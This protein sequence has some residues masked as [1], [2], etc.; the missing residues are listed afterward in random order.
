MFAW[1]QVYQVFRT[2]AVKTLLKSIVQ[3]P[4]PFSSCKLKPFHSFRWSF[5]SHFLFVSCTQSHREA[6]RTPVWQLLL[7]GVVHYGHGCCSTRP[8]APRPAWG[9]I[10]PGLRCPSTRAVRG[11]QFASP[12]TTGLSPAHA[13]AYSVCGS[14]YWEGRPYH[15]ERHQADT[16]Q[17]RPFVTV[18]HLNF[19]LKT[20]FIRL[21]ISKSVPQSGYSSE[22]KCRCSRKTHHN[23]LDTRGLLL[24]LSHDPGH[25]AEGSQ[26][27]QDVSLC[28]ALPR[29]R[30]WRHTIRRKGLAI[31]SAGL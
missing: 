13:R 10:F 8:S 5:L 23:P 28:A 25:H 18:G 22:G 27:D 12:Q 21:T 29:R 20:R 4:S 24:R 31:T 15:Q 2:V 17:V 7:E 16:I 19:M 3:P 9:A 14:H 30:T 6:H 1:M 11:L 26:R